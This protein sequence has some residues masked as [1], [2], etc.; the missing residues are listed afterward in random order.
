MGVHMNQAESPKVMK[1]GLLKTARRKRAE[2]PS[3]DL[4]DTNCTMPIRNQVGADFL[5]SC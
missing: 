1:S 4:R 3:V 2:Y 5:C